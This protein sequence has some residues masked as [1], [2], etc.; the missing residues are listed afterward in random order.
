MEACCGKFNGFQSVPILNIVILQYSN[1]IVIVNL[2][3]CNPFLQILRCDLWVYQVSG[4]KDFHSCFVSL[5]K[6]H[7]NFLSTAYV[8]AEL[9]GIEPPEE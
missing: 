2:L 8:A 7:L 4:I 6:S 3:A 5:P 1:N 9:I